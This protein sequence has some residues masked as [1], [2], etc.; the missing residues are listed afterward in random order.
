MPFLTFYN[1]VNKWMFCLSKC[2]FSVDTA[3][4][5]IRSN[6]M[7]IFIFLIVIVTYEIFLIKFGYVDMHIFTICD[8]DL[9]TMCSY[10]VS[11]S[12]I[13]SHAILSIQ[14]ILM[15]CDQIELLRK[16]G[17]FDK[18]IME[19]LNFKANDIAKS[20]GKHRVVYTF[21]LFCLYNI[22]QSLIIFVLDIHASIDAI[23]FLIGYSIS[24]ICFTATVFNICFYGFFLNHRY[25]AVIMKLKQINH[26][27]NDLN[28]IVFRME[29][30]DI[31]V[32]YYRLMDL[33]LDFLKVFGML[34]LMTIVYHTAV[35]A[36]G[37][38]MFVVSI[39]IDPYKTPIYLIQ[40]IGYGIPFWLRIA[41]LL[42][43]FAP[44]GEQVIITRN[45]PN[46]YYFF[47]ILL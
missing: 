43:V 40:L 21:L 25:D 9:C 47:F 36:I 33:Q 17:A 44:I 5:Q 35:V 27:H 34:L 22:C 24:D 7:Y 23:G 19:K 31:S 15:W 38:Y 30:S 2:P 41:L 3:T 26:N 29:L 42:N 13:H 12:M 14:S 8:S 1:S 20:Y 32:V 18:Y 45:Q 11:M 37:I 6:K 46:H 10:L 4:H 16:I 39:K 28:N